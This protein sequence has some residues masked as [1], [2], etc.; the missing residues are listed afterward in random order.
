MDDQIFRRVL[1]RFSTDKLSFQQ[2]SKSVVNVQTQI[3][4]VREV[5]RQRFLGFFCISQ[6]KTTN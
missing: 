3:I 6:I 4:I 1:F 5:R 2:Q